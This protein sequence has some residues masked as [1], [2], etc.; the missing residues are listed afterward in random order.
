MM[1]ISLVTPAIMRVTNGPVWMRRQKLAYLAKYLTNYWTDFHHLLI[2]YR[3]ISVAIN[4]CIC[5]AM[6]HSVSELQSKE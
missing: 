3:A 4:A 5:N 2:R 6:V 1:K